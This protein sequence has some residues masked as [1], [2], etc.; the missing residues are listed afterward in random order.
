MTE[1]NKHSI[2]S[3]HSHQDQHGHKENLGLPKIPPVNFKDVTP[4]KV[5]NGFMDVL[6]ILKLNKKK[7]D[8]VGA[9]DSEGITLA[10][11]YMALG[12]IATSLGGAIFGYTFMGITVR[13]PILNALLGGLVAILVAFVGFYITNIVAQ[14]LFKGQ[15][16]FPQYFR[17]MGYA[18]LVNVLGVLTILSILGSL[19][20]LWVGL[21][22]NY[23]ALKQIHKL[24]NTNAI[25]AMIVSFVI[26]LILA[27]IVA[28]IGISAVMGGGM[29][30]GFS[31]ISY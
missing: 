23:F 8:E 27:F 16:T 25:L 6:E 4:D 12:A 29:M 5:R 10:L 1:E 15:G 18:S 14:K 24:D 31:S 17:V 20:G 26:T 2:H 13:T 11:I 22:I 28:S 30:G 21:V 3:S 9:R 7:I 19:A